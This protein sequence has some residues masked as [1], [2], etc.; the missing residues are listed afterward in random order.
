MGK[1][2]IDDATA[3]KLESSKEPL[4]LFTASGRQVGQFIPIVVPKRNATEV[5][6]YAWMWNQ[7]SDEELNRRA[8]EPVGRTTE[9]ILKSLG[10]E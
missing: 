7:F 6:K 9:E 2:I 8:K 1:L 4:D 10:A 5:E 3:M